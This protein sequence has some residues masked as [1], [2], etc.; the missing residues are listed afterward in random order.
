MTIVVMDIRG[1]ER[2]DGGGGGF[3]GHVEGF[4]FPGGRGVGGV[5][6]TLYPNIYNVFFYSDISLLRYT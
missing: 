5:G 2:N 6:A 4:D 1:R 3:G